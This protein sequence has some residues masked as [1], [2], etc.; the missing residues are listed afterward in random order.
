L[1]KELDA[2]LILQADV[3]TTDRVIQFTK[4]VMEK[5]CIS[6]DTL[7]ALH[8]LECTHDHLIAKVDALY[9]SLNVRDKFPELEGIS[10]NF[11]HTLLLACDLKINICKW[12]IGSFF[13]WDKLDRAVGGAQKALGVYASRS[14]IY[15]LI[16]LGMKL[17]QQTRKAIAKQQPALMS[18]IHK[19]NAHCKQLEALYDPALPIPIPTP[20]PTKLNDLQNHQLL[21][22]D[23]WISPA[24][25]TISPWVENPD[26]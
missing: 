7:A 9:A 10:L 19:F 16:D 21:M 24:V 12:A 4:N 5:E 18:A 6:D 14:R 17:H 3:D 11:V 8:G 23:V 22:E 26:V 25:G 20:L 1:K 2:V 13:E 15:V